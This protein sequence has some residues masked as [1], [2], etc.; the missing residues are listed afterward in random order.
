[1]TFDLVAFTRLHVAISLVAIAS[2][3]VML[4]G[5]LHAWRRPGWTA[6]FLTTTAATSITGF[7][8]PVDRFLPSHA[9]GIVSLLVLPVAV[10]AR[11]RHHLT[12]RWRS[13]YVIAA[14]TVLYL[15]VFVLVAQAFQKVPA[16]H[17]LAPS[18]SEPPFALAQGAVLFF[19]VA[20]TTAA[21]VRFRKEHLPVQR[22]MAGGARATPP[23]LGVSGD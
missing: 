11:Y 17:E 22:A 21:V 16:L 23:A 3:F 18:G 12:G 2:G 6:V 10:V 1:M 14:M 5:L 20:A 19:F 8:F 7:L 15:N 13:A 4:S 9:V